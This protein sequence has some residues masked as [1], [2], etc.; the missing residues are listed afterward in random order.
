V[1][2]AGWWLQ[3]NRGVKLLLTE[4]IKANKENEI[5]YPISVLLLEASGERW[6]DKGVCPL[7]Q[8]GDR[9]DTQRINL[10]QIPASTSGIWQSE[11]PLS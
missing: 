9:R 4:E 5:A 10:L 7:D 3:F 8:I 1:G 2:V 6:I 11:E